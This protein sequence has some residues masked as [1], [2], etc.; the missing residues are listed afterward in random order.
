MMTLII[1]Q[2]LTETNII[3]NNCHSNL[4]KWNCYN[5]DNSRANPTIINVYGGAHNKA[6]ILQYTGCMCVM[7]CWLLWACFVPTYSTLAY[8]IYVLGHLCTIRSTSNCWRPNALQILD[9]DRLTTQGVHYHTITSQMC[10]RLGW[11]H[12]AP[13]HCTNACKVTS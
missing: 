13:A 4:C 8:K 11:V 1:G 12:E 10:T 2:K 6:T 5:W 7:K 9:T 3:Y